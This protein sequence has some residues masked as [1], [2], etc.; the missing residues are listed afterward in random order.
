MDPFGTRLEAALDQHGPV[1]AGLDPH[2]SLLSAWGL[3]DDADGVRRFSQACVEAWAGRV[4][5]VKP[6]SA[7][8]E[9]HGSAGIAVLEETVAAFRAAGTLV[10]LDVKRG[11]IGSTAQ[12]YAEAY[13]DPAAPLAVDAITAS[14]FL[15]VGS[16]T[17]MVDLARAHGAGLFVLALT[18]NP[19]APQVQLAR[20]TVGPDAGRTVA[21]TV[22]AALAELNGATPSGASGGAANAPLGSFGAVV[23]ATVAPSEELTAALDFGGPVLMPGVGAQGGTVAAVR[24]LA[25]QARQRVVPSVS[26][27]LLGAGPDPQALREAAASLNDTFRAALRG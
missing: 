19:E 12:A 20:T 9:R 21:T 22:L 11:D 14:P 23:G 17:P 15:G 10:L 6:Q 27:E 24:E 7:F 3:D 1:C 4:A 16:L 8:Y 18:S 2:A 26:R 25:G 5:L 13:L